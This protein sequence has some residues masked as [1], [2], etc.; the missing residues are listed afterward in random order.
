MLSDN[1]GFNTSPHPGQSQPKIT[2]TALALTNGSADT[3]TT[4][5]VTAG[6]RY[7][8]TSYKTG[9]FLF[10]LAT[11]ATA[12][13][14]RWVCPLYATIEIQIPVGYT[15]LHYQTNVN[16]GLGYLVEIKQTSDSDATE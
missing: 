5:T 16:N 14:I 3:N 9:G 12:G 6:S 7:R 2:Q 4:Q 10:G 15:T 11:T 13:N 1:G 8:F